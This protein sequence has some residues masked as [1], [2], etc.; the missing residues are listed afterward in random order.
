MS[1][2]FDARAA[3]GFDVAGERKGQAMK[4][5]TYA[6][7]RTPPRNRRRRAGDP[8]AGVDVAAL[9]RCLRDHAMGRRMLKPT[10]QRAAEIVL[11]KLLPDLAPSKEGAPT[12]DQERLEQYRAHKERSDWH[13]AH[14]ARRQRTPESR[15]EVAVAIGSEDVASGAARRH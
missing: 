6:F 2:K 12:L 13:A 9:L 3:R 7:S 4:R 8:C 11:D 10:Q 15:A 14:R 5:P 1:A